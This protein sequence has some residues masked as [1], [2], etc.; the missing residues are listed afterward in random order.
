MTLTDAGPLVALL[1]KNDGCHAE[2][3]EAAL[4]LPP[5]PFLSTWPCFAEA[6]HLIYRDSGYSG[7]V[8]LWQL[9]QSKKLVLHDLQEAEIRR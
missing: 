6:M 9:F 4:T 2:C 5:D 7:Q 8:R 1:D 3:V